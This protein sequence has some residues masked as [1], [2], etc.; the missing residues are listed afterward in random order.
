MLSRAWVISFLI[1]F[2]FSKVVF[3]QV[4]VYAEDENGVIDNVVIINDTPYVIFTVQNATEIYVKLRENELHSQE[5]EKLEKELEITAKIL[6]DQ[7]FL[8][9][10]LERDRIAN[11][12]L[13]A[14]AMENN[15]AK[16]EKWFEQPWVV[17]GTAFLLTGAAYGYWS[18]TTLR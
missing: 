17:F 16:E 1:V 5:I 8:I 9:Q 7:K 18:Y 11:R 12:E 10:F 3:P 14:L 6:E 15:Q 4:C 13:L 2:L